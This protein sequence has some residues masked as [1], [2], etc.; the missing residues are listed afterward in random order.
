MRDATQRIAGEGDKVN[1]AVKKIF[2]TP[3]KVPKREIEKCKKYVSACSNKDFFDNLRSSKLLNCLN[4][5]PIRRAR[6]ASQRILGGGSVIKG[7]LQT[8][9]NG[10]KNIPKNALRK[11]RKIV[12][13]IKNK[14]L[15]YNIRSPKLQNALERI[16]RKSMKEANESF[17]GIIFASH[18]S[19]PQLSEWMKF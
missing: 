14:K 17:K 1:G 10:L 19:E 11:W 2:T 18:K 5:I 3:Q 7:I 4:R 15:F 9:I 13:D 8:L 6:G 12:Q 16:V